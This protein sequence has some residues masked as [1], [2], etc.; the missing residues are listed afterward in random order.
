MRRTPTRGLRLLLAAAPGWI[1][2]ILGIA[3]MWLGIGLL[4]TSPQ[5][6]IKAIVEFDCISQAVTV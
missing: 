2:P 4:I 3:V 1:W 6:R 5:S